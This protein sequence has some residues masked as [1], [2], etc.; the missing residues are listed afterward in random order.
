MTT[1]ALL[2]ACSTPAKVNEVDAQTQRDVLG[3]QSNPGSARVYIFTGK[4]IGGLFNSNHTFP[5]D[6]YVNTTQIGSINNENVM[7]FELKPGHYDFSWVARNNDLIVK[8]TVPLKSNFDLL[9]GQILVL[10][11]DYDLGGTHFG[12][13]GAMINHPS[14]VIVKA[15]QDDVLQKKV[16]TPQTCD[17]G[18]CVRRIFR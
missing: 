13:I 16:V 7:Y 12:L 14:T 18:L 5:A 17:P 3:F 1:F 9:A 8:Q 6:I 11:G 15:Q 4:L 10:R 2:G